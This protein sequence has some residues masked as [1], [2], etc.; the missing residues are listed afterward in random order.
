MCDL[1][2]FC[3]FPMW[4]AGS[5]VVLHCIDSL[6]LHSSFLH[7]AA[8]FGV[9]LMRTILSYLRYPGYLNFINGPISHVLLL[10]LINVQQ[11]SCL[12]V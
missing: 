6:S 4:C 1:F 11:L 7:M 5:G 3:Y 2:L 9:F 8:K 12:F 10:I